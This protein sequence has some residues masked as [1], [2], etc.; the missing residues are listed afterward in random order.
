MKHS[1]LSLVALL[2]TSCVACA[3]SPVSAVQ[4]S[5]DGTGIG[6][7]VRQLIIRVADDGGATSISGVNRGVGEF[8]IIVSSNG[9]M[10]L[11]DHGLTIRLDGGDDNNGGGENPPVPPTNPG[12]MSDQIRAATQQWIKTVPATSAHRKMAV[13]EAIYAVV[14]AAVIDKTLLTTGD[15][16]QALRPLLL[17]ATA[18]DPGWSEFGKSYNA[19][20]AKRKESK[21]IHDVT[22]YSTALVAVIEG[23]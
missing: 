13:M 4:V 11:V 22:T 16:D 8:A 18:G 19:E 23:L 9:K 20:I 6:L 2:L 5:R 15:M 3:Q 10:I 12:S 21:E 7:V 1:L 14:K 17:N